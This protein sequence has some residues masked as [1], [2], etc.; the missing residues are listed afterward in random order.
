MLWVFDYHDD[1]LTDVNCQKIVFEYRDI[2]I[3]YKAVYN[4]LHH[5]Q[6]VAIEEQNSTT[7]SRASL[8][9]PQELILAI[10]DPYLQVKFK[11]RYVICLQEH[12]IKDLH[13]KTIRG[14]KGSYVVKGKA[15]I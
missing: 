7:P 13:N 11:G 15:V 14:T 4:I 3:L 12:G 5:P 6:D 2:V 8:G 10:L 1:K 9:K